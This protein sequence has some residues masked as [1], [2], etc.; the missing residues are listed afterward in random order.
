MPR[1]LLHLRPWRRHSVVLGV[2]GLVYLL[3]GI[4]LFTLDPTTTRVNGLVVALEVMD[5]DSWG[6]V[7]T[8]VGLAA[9]ASTRWPPQSET[10]GYALMEFLAAFW[11]ACYFLAMV[12]ALAPASN[13]TGGLVWTMIA[14]LWW[15]VSGL[16]NPD[17]MH[18]PVRFD[19]S[20]YEPTHKGED[21]QPRGRHD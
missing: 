1:R 9:I 5:Y 20:I 4:A 19:W 8:V 6:I 2:A 10:W 21:E 18:R 13:V 7:W 14:F 3:Y 12:F 16:S 11:A 15:A 17:D